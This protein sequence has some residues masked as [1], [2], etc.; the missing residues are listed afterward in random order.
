M[1]NVLVEGGGQVIGSF[2]DARHVDEVHVFIAPRLFGGLAAP[3]PI[4]GLGAAQVAESLRLEGVEIQATGGDVYLHG[5]VVRPPT[6][7]A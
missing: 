5:R 6:A 3:G 7:D 4:A 2:F 1:T